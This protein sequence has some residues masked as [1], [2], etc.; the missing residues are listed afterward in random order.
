MNRLLYRIIFNK[1]RGMLMVVSELA[2]SCASSVS[3]GH[4]HRRLVC[5]VSAISL[6]LWLASGAISVQASIVADTSAPG[7]QQP[8][9]ISSANG[10]PQVNIQ[11]PLCRGR[12]PQYLQPV[13]R[14]SEGGHS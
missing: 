3:I 11:T 10:T 6:S 4:N 13:R 5:R 14:R 12:L 7:K 9:I 2:R 1:A 8:T